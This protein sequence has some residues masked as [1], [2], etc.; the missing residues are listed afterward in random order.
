MRL[1]P[2]TRT[3]REIAEF[4]QA[5]VLG[6]ETLQLKGISSIE[7]SVPGDLIFV[8]DE[9]NLPSA[10]GSRATA[11]IAGEFAVG[12]TNSKTLLLATQPR[13]A[14]ARAAQLLYAGPERNPGIHPS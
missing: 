6:D 1:L 7:S 12:K 5:R 14:F 2:K 10:L 8:D 13:L 11:V 9:K 4:V 3:V